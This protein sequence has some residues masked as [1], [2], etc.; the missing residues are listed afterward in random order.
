MVEYMRIIA[1]ECK[2]VVS[3]L[4]DANDMCIGGWWYVLCLSQLIKVWFARNVSSA[5]DLHHI[6]EIQLR[7]RVI[8]RKMWMVNSNR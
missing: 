4:D 5:N 3:L 8:D 2:I 6:I 7:P 1:I